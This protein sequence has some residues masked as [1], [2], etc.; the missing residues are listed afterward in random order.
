MAAL[1]RTA[2]VTLNYQGLDDTRACLQSLQE[3]DYP[4]DRWTCV[5]VDNGSGAG[6]AETLAREFPWAEHWPNAEN[7][8]FTGGCNGAMRRLLAD[9]GYEYIALLNNDTVVEPTWLQALVARA[10]QDP[11]TG[12]VT[13]LMTFFAE[14]DVVENAGAIA[15]ISADNMPIG[16]GGSVARY[17]QARPRMIFCGG[18]V[19]LRRGMLEELG[20]FRDDFFANF[21]DVDLSLRAQVAGWNIWYEPR[22]VVRHKLSATIDK[23]RSREFLIRSQRNMLWTAVCNLPLPVLLANS[24][25]FLL[26]E[27]L[28]L[29]VCP[30]LGLRGVAGS[31]W[32]SRRRIWAERRLWLAARREV[33]ARQ[34]VSSWTLFWRQGMCLPY[35]W[36]PFFRD[37]VLRR[38]RSYMNAAVEPGAAPT[39]AP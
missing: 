25:F 38:R 9:E 28:L 17:R 30:L 33:L 8:G 3:L 18:A 14:P 31:V 26:R 24:P 12:A 39:T 29:V 2:V 20:L 5:V 10:E 13:S 7:L 6:E 15:L 23:V 35:Y 37:V 1:P 27:F 16:R 19:L 34:R 36:W 22:A 11:R 21:E 32:A 4:Q